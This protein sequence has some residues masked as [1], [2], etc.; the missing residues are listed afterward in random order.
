MCT[1]FM[2]LKNS[3]LMDMDDTLC[4]VHWDLDSFVL[5]LK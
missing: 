5:Q 4:A 2:F 3:V 1:Y